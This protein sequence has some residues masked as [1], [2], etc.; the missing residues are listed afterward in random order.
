MTYILGVDG[1]GSKTQA[2][3]ANDKGIKIA[4]GMAGRGN[5]QISGIQSA[6][7]E[8]RK[9]VD[10]ALT[11]A[12]LTYSDISFTQYGLAGADRQK[13]FDILRP[14]LAEL[15]LH[16]WQLVCDT[17][18]GLRIGSSD[19]TGV[20]LVC[21]M[22]TNAAGRDSNGDTVQIGGFGYLYGDAAGGSYMAEETFRLAV[23]SWEGRERS[24][25]LP[26]KVAHFHEKD[27]MQAVLDDYLDHEWTEVP[28]ALNMLL[29]EAAAEGDVLAITFLQQVGRELGNAANAVIER[30]GGF[31]N[32][33][34]PIVLTGSVLQ[35]GQDAHLITAL[36]DS[37]Q[38]KHPNIHI[39]NPEMSPVYGAILLAMDHLNITVTEDIK[40]QFKQYGGMTYEK[41]TT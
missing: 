33:D 8:I 19:N 12:G 37:I 2:V 1:G 21:G 34:I 29:H 17:M 28:A 40:K 20:V 41:T 27:D 6:I 10:Q 26:V 11:Y 24:S 5:H 4:E 23:R 38:A 30:L 18:E 32:K 16:P 36:R 39:V 7:R 31:S 25:L 14:A 13:D 15:P 9:A 22:G 3:I 35:K